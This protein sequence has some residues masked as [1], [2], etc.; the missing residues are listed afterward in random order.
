M[1]KELFLKADPL[2]TF[3]INTQLKEQIKWLIGIGKIK[4][5]DMLPP[6]QQLAD[7][8]N[9]NRNTVNLVYTQ[10][11]DEGIVSMQKGRGTQ[12]LNNAK[13]EELISKRKPMAAIMGKVVQEAE[14]HHFDLEQL[15]MAG[16]AY[17]QLFGRKGAAKAKLLF[18]ECR[19]H[20]HIF[21]R[22]EIEKHTGAQVSS[23]FLEDIHANKVKLDELLNGVDAV[24]TTLNHDDEVKQMVGAKK[25]VITIGAT[26]DFSLLLEIAKLSPGTKVGFVCLGQKGGQWMAR[27]AMDA[28]I[29]HIE[30]VPAGTN[31]MET[32]QEVIRSADKLF[33]STAV[34]D[35]L[36]RIA[37]EKVVH[38]PLTLEKSSEKLLIEYSH[39]NGYK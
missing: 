14:E 17:V 18:L 33:A 31:D 6:A 15:M 29:G 26:V 37:P 8:L 39:A 3:S 36:K 21:Y 22:H 25:S 7:T 1:D 16:I 10:L 38:F 9:V 4:P 32:L 35:E 23:A 20:D 27:R 24:V 28:G 19:E 5:G 2:L 11:R 12:V 13:I 30:A 34:F